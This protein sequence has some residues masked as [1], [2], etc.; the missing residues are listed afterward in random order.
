M[1]LWR[2]TPI[3]FS[4]GAGRCR[5]AYFSESYARDGWG[6]P[7]PLVPSRLEGKREQLSSIIQNKAKGASSK[8]AST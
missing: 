4:F 2:Q 6:Y 1:L 8:G 7:R 3:C 5:L